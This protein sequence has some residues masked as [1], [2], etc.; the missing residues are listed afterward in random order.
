MD[1]AFCP[2]CGAQ[3]GVEVIIQHY[4][5]LECVKCSKTVI[6]YPADPHHVE[7]LRRFFAKTPKKSK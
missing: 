6:V 1:S 4:T 2:T 7:D 3:Q 5:I